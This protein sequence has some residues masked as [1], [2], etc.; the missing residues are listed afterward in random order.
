METAIRHVAQRVPA[1]WSAHE[2]CFDFEAAPVNS[3]NEQLVDGSLTAARQVGH[4]ITRAV[5]GKMPHDRAAF[6][7]A[8]NVIRAEI[9]RR[10]HESTGRTAGVAVGS[11]ATFEERPRAGPQLQR[12]DPSGP[13]TKPSQS[14]SAPGRFV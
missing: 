10:H 7:A 3:G 4:K 2:R 1:N 5:V 6:S 8:Q 13:C 12:E 9:E 14:P 11:G